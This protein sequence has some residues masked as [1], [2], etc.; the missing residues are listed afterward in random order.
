MCEVNIVIKIDVCEL[1]RGEVKSFVS[2]TA[3]K[4]QYHS[5][6]LQL[7]EIVRLKPETRNLYH[8]DLTRSYC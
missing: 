7:A 5:W 2:K 1:N 6:I 3:T 8:Q 4:R